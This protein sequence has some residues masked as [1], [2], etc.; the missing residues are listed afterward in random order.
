M[1]L[2]QVNVPDD[3]K[4]RAD[5]AFARSGIT[6]PGAMRM[7]VTKVANEDKTPFDGLFFADE[8]RVLADDVRRDMVRTEAQ[9]FGLL[10]DDAT[11][12]TIIPEGILA[13][14]GLTAHDVDQ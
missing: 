12:A 10:P 7:M 8:A 1:A 9:E 4:Q 3:V 2:I 11:D 14:L 5:A 13:E 6:T